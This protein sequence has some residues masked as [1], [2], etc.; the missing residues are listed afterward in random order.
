MLKKL[1]YISI[2]FLAFRQLLY[3]LSRLFEKEETEEQMK[4]RIRKKFKQH[5]SS[6]A[7]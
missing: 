4:E 3:D 6:P 7:G 5:Q 2:L 1:V